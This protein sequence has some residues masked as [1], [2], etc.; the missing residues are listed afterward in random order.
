MRTHE[1]P[2]TAIDS[3]TRFYVL[4]LWKATP[5]RIPFHNLAVE[6]P[7]MRQVRSRHVERPDVD[8]AT[9]RLCMWSWWGL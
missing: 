9:N 3:L 2:T 8:N 7:H 1:S 5:V 6:V 4:L